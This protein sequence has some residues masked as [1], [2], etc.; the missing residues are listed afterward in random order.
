V[1]QLKR[2]WRKTHWPRK[3]L[4][5]GKSTGPALGV[6]ASQFQGVEDRAPQRVNLYPCATQPRLY[7]VFAH[8]ASTLEQIFCSAPGGYMSAF[9]PPVL[10]GT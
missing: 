8:M 1:S 2:H 5:I 7:L 10:C 9:S 6:L 4:R 3:D